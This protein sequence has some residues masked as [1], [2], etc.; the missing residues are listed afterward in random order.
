MKNSKYKRSQIKRSTIKRS[1]IMR[2]EKEKGKII[3]K[4][5]LIFL[6]TTHRLKENKSTIL[7][8]TK[9]IQINKIKNLRNQNGSFE[10]IQNKKWKGWISFNWRDISID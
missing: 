2:K 9:K 10:S 5:P 6:M 4:I 3:L 1:I 8:S 7:I